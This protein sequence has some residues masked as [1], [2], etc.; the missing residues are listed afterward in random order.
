MFDCFSSFRGRSHRIRPNV[1]TAVDGS[2]F[3]SLGLATDIFG[4][5]AISDQILFCPS[6]TN[7]CLD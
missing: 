6:L 1:P 3:G 4:K 2:A 7:L 5:I